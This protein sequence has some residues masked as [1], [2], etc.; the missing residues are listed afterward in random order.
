[1]HNHN[2]NGK[3]T[4]PLSHS[5]TALCSPL[6]TKDG[7]LPLHCCG[8]GGMS[9]AK[10][11]LIDLLSCDAFAGLI[12]FWCDPWLMRTF[13]IYFYINSDQMLLIA[14]ESLRWKESESSFNP[15]PR[16]AGSQP[17]QHSRYSNTLCLHP[18]TAI[19]CTLPTK[20]AHCHPCMARLA[21][22][23]NL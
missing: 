10:M 2:I 4:P 6:L 20:G 19:P 21:E 5:S 9:M 11:F 18:P 23:I 14:I 7:P 8:L 17:S 22:Q 13:W 3:A 1:M 12:W 15:A 16:S